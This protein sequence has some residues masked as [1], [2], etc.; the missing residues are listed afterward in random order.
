[1]SITTQYTKTINAFPPLPFKE[2]EATR[3]TLQR[4]IQIIGKI[5]LSLM[6]RKNHWWNIPLYVSPQGLTTHSIPY[7]GR[8]FEIC[9]DFRK[10][11]LLIDTSWNKQRIFILQH[12]LSVAQFYNML[13]N[14]LQDLGIEVTILAKPYELKDTVPFAEDY[15][16]ASYDSKY[17]Y[18]FWQILLQVDQ[19]FKEFSGRF[20]GKTSPVHF[21]WHSFDL[22]V[23]RFSGKK[24][25]GMQEGSIVNK[26]SY[27]HEVISFGFWPGDDEL[28]EP[29]FYSYTYPSP[30]G[31]DQQK[32]QPEKAYW[33]ERRGSP[34]ALY[35]Y[36]DFREEKDPASSLLNFLES[37]Y[38]AGAEKAGWNIKELEVKPLAEWKK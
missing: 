37:A 11:Q 16:H 38:K 12:E 23:T 34:L 19:L 8:S 20:Y 32:L 1:M 9:L 21:F 22:A 30:E 28:R 6:P 13:F 18:Q 35:K 24:A 10:H 17:V 7:K 29:A 15:G 33:S 27:S 31:L 26:E 3:D 4:Y 5:K 25:P 36:E 14:S 2:W